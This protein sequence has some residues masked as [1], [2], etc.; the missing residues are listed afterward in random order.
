MEYEYETPR[1]RECEWSSRRV[2]RDAEWSR[3]LRRAIPVFT[4]STSSCSW[5]LASQLLV[6]TLTHT[7]AEK[8]LS[9]ALRVGHWSGRPQQS[10]QLL[11][12][13]GRA[14]AGATPCARRARVQRARRVPLR[15][16]PSH[17][18]ASSRDQCASARAAAAARTL[19][20]YS[21]T[22]TSVRVAPAEQAANTANA[23]CLVCSRLPLHILV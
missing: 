14:G 22:R 1:V 21:I 15:P 17:R 6:L 4:I 3:T 12:P 23:A 11:V 19:S 8:A 16:V 9:K 10:K 2:A 5:V 7:R 13:W 18:V 20:T